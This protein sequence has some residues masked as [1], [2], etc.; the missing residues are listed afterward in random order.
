MKKED[1]MFKTNDG[2]TAITQLEHVSIKSHDHTHVEGDTVFTLGRDEWEWLFRG[3][4][5]QRL[6]ARPSAAWEE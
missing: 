3:A 6:H 2:L 1:S 5:W 4:D